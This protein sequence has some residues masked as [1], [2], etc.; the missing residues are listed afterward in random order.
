MKNIRLFFVAVIPVIILSCE[1]HNPV[2]SE[3]ADLGGVSAIFSLKD[4]TGLPLTQF[5]TGQSI[6]M[7]CTIRNASSSDEVFYQPSPSV[8]FRIAGTGG[9]ISTSA[10]SMMFPQAIAIRTLSAGDSI[11]FTWRGPNNSGRIQKVTLPP[12]TYAAQAVMRISFQSAAV[13]APGDI[14]FTVI[15]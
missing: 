12:G 3:P 1:R 4:T 2:A 5:H 7:T 8:I 14:Q 9:T 15:P 13:N 11:S 6:D 10:D